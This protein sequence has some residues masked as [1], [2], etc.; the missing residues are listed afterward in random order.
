MGTLYRVCAVLAFVG[1]ALAVVAHFTG[2]DWSARLFGGRRTIGSD[3]LHFGIALAAAYVLV[4]AL[5]PRAR[6]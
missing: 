5:R 2:E 1:C 4:G 6:G 3:M